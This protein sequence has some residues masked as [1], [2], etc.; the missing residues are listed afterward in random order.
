VAGVDRPN[1]QEDQR[2]VIL[3]YDTGEDG[4]MLDAAEHAR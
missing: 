4:T 2:H 1:I 3:V